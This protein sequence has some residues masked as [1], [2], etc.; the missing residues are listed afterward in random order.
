M[1]RFALIGL[2]VLTA[3][4]AFSPVADAQA[5]E[6]PLTFRVTPRSFLDPGNVVP[7]GSIGGSTV[8]MSYRQTF[9]DRPTAWW[10][11]RDLYGEGLLPDPAGG[12]GPWVGAANPFGPIGP[13]LP[14]GVPQ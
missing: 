13:N 10:S 7:P 12:P 11:A 4:M 3:G 9:V 6:R 5:Q 8:T 2:G 14:T 1:R